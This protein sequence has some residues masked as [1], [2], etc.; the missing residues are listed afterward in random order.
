[1]LR[2]SFMLAVLVL[3]ALVGGCGG[4]EEAGGTGT[5]EEESV[6]PAE[7]VGE[8]DQIETLL[9]DALARYR[10]GDAEE[11]EQIVGDAYLEH[12]EKVEHPL[13]EIDHELMEE[14][15]VLISTTLRDE[16]RAGASFPEV[17][18]LVAEAKTGLAE[19]KSLLQS[20]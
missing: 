3:A 4:S 11:A 1:M 6:T 19:A 2:R 9:D 16:I 5:A 20:S 12:F 7:A 17:E 18:G 13:E 8:I 14:L 10:A 15:E